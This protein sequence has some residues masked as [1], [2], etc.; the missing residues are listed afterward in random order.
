MVRAGVVEAVGFEQKIPF[1]VPLVMTG[2]SGKR[3]GGHRV[4]VEKSVL[5]MARMGWWFVKEGSS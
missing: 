2:A 4:F 1:R 5:T 3:P